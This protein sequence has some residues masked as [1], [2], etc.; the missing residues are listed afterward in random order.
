MT[1]SLQSAKNSYQN[2]LKHNDGGNHNE[3]KRENC[4]VGRDR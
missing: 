1:R 4:I 3:Y 2:V